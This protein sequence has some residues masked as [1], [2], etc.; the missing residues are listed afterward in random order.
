MSKCNFTKSCLLWRVLV[1]AVTFASVFAG[2]KNV[3]FELPKFSVTAPVCRGQE[4]VFD[5]Y[6]SATVEIQKIQIKMN[7]FDKKT[8]GPAFK[9]IVAVECSF[10]CSILPSQSQQFY[11]S[12]AEYLQ[13]TQAVEFLIDNF[14]ISRVSYSDGKEW[15]DDFGL[16]SQVYLSKGE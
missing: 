9:N 10:D 8:G 11:A 2:C 6:N 14:Y 16:Y 4:V 7:V 5:F 3:T 15:K 1:F 13:D 12:L